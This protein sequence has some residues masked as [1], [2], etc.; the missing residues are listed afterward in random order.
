MNWANFKQRV[1]EVKSFFISYAIAT[2]LYAIFGIVWI[3]FPHIISIINDFLE[4]LGPAARIDF[5]LY[6]ICI[7]PVAIAGFA[8]GYRK[9]QDSQDGAGRSR[10]DSGL[11]YLQ[12]YT[13]VGF[14]YGPCIWDN[15][16]LFYRILSPEHV[17]LASPME[18]QFVFV[19]FL[20]IS[21]YRFFTI[22]YVIVGTYFIL[23]VRKRSQILWVYLFFIY[24][25]S[26]LVIGLF[27]GLE[28][29]PKSFFSEAIGIYLLS[30]LLIFAIIAILYS[31]IKPYKEKVF[32]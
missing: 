13:L 19:F 9:L 24:I 15:I 10:I 30:A 12:L 28:I 3:F 14:I 32:N 22:I 6:L 31:F 2:V 17:N 23:Y 7:I 29:N 27:F 11:Y 20:T 26:S 21:L 18:I 1:L 25:Y 8:H 5:F 16:I 4:K